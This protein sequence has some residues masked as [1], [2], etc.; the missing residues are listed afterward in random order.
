MH[1]LIHFFSQFDEIF[2]KKRLIL[3]GGN[4]NGGLTVASRVHKVSRASSFT[5]SIKPVS[6]TLC[7]CASRLTETQGAYKT[8][9]V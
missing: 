3:E 9:Y 1:K 6:N 7:A 4:G 5:A 2:S 8:R